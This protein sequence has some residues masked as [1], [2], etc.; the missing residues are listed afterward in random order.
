M[1]ALT[2]SV[3]DG[4]PLDEDLNLPLESYT[5]AEIRICPELIHV[6]RFAESYQLRRSSIFSTKYAICCHNAAVARNLKF[7]ATARMWTVLASLYQLIESADTDGEIEY[8]PTSPMS[9]LFHSTV[10]DLLLERAD[11]ADVQTVVAL[12]EVIGVLP[13]STSSTETTALKSKLPGITV[14]MVREWYLSYID[15]L[16]QMCLF[17]YATDLIK[18][19]Q[20]SEIQKLNQQ[21]TMY[22][23][24]IFLHV[25]SQYFSF[26]VHYHLPKHLRIMSYL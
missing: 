2:F 17:S 12:C 25:K 26:N 21:S 1:V 3:L 10:Q 14:L 7:D 16:Q 15:I 13:V 23:L 18:N 11:A 8:S 5:K 6:S 19:C 20:D 9:V 22:V 4:G 24:S